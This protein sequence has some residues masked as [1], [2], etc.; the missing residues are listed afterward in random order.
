[1]YEHPE[2]T[3]AE[4]RE[5]T[6]RHRPGRLEPLLRAGA[7][8]GRTSTLLAIYSHM[9]AYALYL[10]DYPLGHM[11]AFQMEDATAQAGDFGAEFERM[12]SQGRLTPGR[13][14]CSGR[15]ALRSARSRC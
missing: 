10:P 2:A 12:A 8:A 5:A 15:R 14:G 4:L 6:L 13:S 3:P 9:I 7:S 11:I 1:M